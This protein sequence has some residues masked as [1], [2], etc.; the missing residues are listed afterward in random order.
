MITLQTGIPEGTFDSLINL[1]MLVMHGNVYIGDASTLNGSTFQP[2]KKLEFLVIDGFR[3]MTFDYH[4]LNTRLSILIL[5]CK[6]FGCALNIVDDGIFDG[7]LHLQI[8]SMRH[9]HISSLSPV[10]LARLKSLRYL[11]ISKNDHLGMQHVLGPVAKALMD[12]NIK[13]LVM[14]LVSNPYEAVNRLDNENLFYINQLN[15]TELHMDSNSIGIIDHNKPLFSRYF[16]LKV[17][18]LKRNVLS[19]GLFVDSLVQTNPSIEVLDFGNQ[20]W[21]KNIV[22]FPVEKTR[23]RTI[24]YLNVSNLN[25]KKFIFTGS[26][27]HVNVLNFEYFENVI[28]YIDISC[29]Y[30]NKELKLPYLLSLT[31]LNISSNLIETLSE[32]VFRGTPSL[33]YL[34]IRDNILGFELGSDKAVNIFVPL[35]H[36]KTINL[37]KNRIYSLTSSLFSQCVSLQ[38]IGLSENYL[39]IFDLNLH[40]LRNLSVLNLRNNRLQTLSEPVRVYLSDMTSA[41]AVIVN[42]QDNK[43]AGNCDNIEF[44]RWLVTTNVSLTGKH[45]Y[46][47]Y[48]NNA[49]ISR[50]ESSTTDALVTQCYTYLSLIT[51][52]TAII[53]VFVVI[54]ISAIIFRYRW[55]IVYWYYNVVKRRD[56]N[57]DARHDMFQYDAY[58]AYDDHETSLVVRTIHTK[59]E[60][61]SNLRLNI[62][63]RA[64]PLGDINALNIVEAI[65]SSRKTI[66]L[67]SRHFLKNKWCRFE[68]N[69]AII[70][71]IT[72]NRPVTVIVYVEDIPVRFLP[73]EVSKLLQDS[74]V[75]DFPNDTDA[76]PNA[77]W[78]RLKDCISR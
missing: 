62:R 43:L 44:L 68:I 10:A 60:V 18:S 4:F 48:Y 78:N 40:N 74:P 15:L 32:S 37:S 64:F 34:E 75:F 46:N 23:R 6:C 28:E 57:M 31:F 29:N 30:L 12:S 67:L 49:S 22:N 5:K 39:D 51:S 33:Q 21:F 54:N 26:K 71:A 27:S 11:D 53:S 9:C 19:Y 50:I 63:D 58:L 8:L 25:L 38:N 35:K 69:I 61:E 13:I 41:H 17:L 66:L 42:L 59:L 3:N 56:T 70:E 36:L 1:R 52:L 14:N 2:L 16:T 20:F 77:F 45:F 24:E 65:S 55:H 47:C 73:K 7:L 76:S 72:A